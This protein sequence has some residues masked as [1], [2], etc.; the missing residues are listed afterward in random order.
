V[1]I[2]EFKTTI[3]KALNNCHAV[4]SYGPVEADKL[5]IGVAMYD[6]AEFFIILEE[7]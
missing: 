4:E 6:G 7:A 2:H 3:E 1:D 5:T